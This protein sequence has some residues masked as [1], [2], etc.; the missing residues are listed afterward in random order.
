MFD[1]TDL[2]IVSQDEYKRLVQVSERV[3]VLERIVE[4]NDY[5]PVEEIR[6]ILD[7]K[8]LGRSEVKKV[9]GGGL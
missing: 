3:S 5:I 6:A 4:R 8:P 9:Q 2:V 7:F 1:R